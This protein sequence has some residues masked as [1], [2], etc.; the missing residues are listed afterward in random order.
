[1]Q[2]INIA[3]AKTTE[4]VAF[5]NTHAEKPVKKFVSRAVAEEKVA[6]IIASLPTSTT[7][8]KS[9]AAKASW[10]NETV[11]AA[12]AARH[13]VKVAGEEYPSVAKAFEA[14][15]LPMSKH[16]KFRK[17]LKLAGKLVF[18]T[19]TGDKLNFAVV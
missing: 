4:L 10:T 11:R 19:E 2:T 17:E 18:T 6:A 14:L 5:Y 15:A 13:G 7:E 16:V 12:R 8:K 9:A 3:E 1:M